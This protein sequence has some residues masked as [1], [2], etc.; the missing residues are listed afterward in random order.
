MSPEVQ[1][2]RFTRPAGPSDG[3]LLIAHSSPVF[4]RGV[5][6]DRW[7]EVHCAVYHG[8]TVDRIAEEIACCGDRHL[9]EH[10]AF[11]YNDGP[12]PAVPHVHF[13]G[14]GLEY[15]IRQ[16]DLAREAR[17]ALLWI[18]GSVQCDDRAVRVAP[19]AC[20]P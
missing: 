4:G 6:W 13:D 20:L 19:G 8:W 10:A 18:V 12:A 14:P 9:E 15:A 17:A 11:D 1:T 16:S 7:A 5:D 3:Y 2:D